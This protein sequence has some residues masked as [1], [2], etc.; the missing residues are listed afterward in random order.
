MGYDRDEFTHMAVAVD[1]LS[2]A[3]DCGM[4]ILA[5]AKALNLDFVPIEEEQYDLIVPSAILDQPNV[6]AVLETIQSR[7]FRERVT[8]L[9]GYD[10]SK[11]GQLWAQVG[12]TVL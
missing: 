2:A 6:Q 8:A 12:G 7:H 10:A 11:S 4:G 3:A 9:G 5:A 1:V